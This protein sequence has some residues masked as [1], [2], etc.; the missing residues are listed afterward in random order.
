MK[1]HL[2]HENN[3]LNCGTIVQERYCSH[4]GQEN[5]EVKESFNHLVRHF[6]EDVTHYDSKFFT[7]IK[8]LIFKP[9]FLTKEYL[10]GRRASYLHP[11]RL[12]VFTS[13]LYFLAAFA[14]SHNSEKG[15][16]AIRERIVYVAKKEVADSL[17]QMLAQTTS[18]NK[19]DSIRRDVLGNAMSRLKLDS[20]RAA[21]I[22]V[23]LIGNI[24]YKMLKAYD[25]TQHA[26]PESQRDKGLKPWLYSRWLATIEHH[27]EAVINLLVE[28]TQ[29]AVPKLMFLL[30]PLFALFLK[31]FYDRKKYYYADHA[32]FSLHFH[33]AVFLLFLVFNLINKVLPSLEVFNT[34]LELVLVIIFLVVALKNTYQQKTAVSVGKAL[35]LSLLYGTFIVAGFIII[36]LSALL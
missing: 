21:E 30:L 18:G 7:T 14:F 23:Q 29:H 35:G 20:L 11:I 2:R 16:E 5:T 26:L 28:K 33:S 31:L 22:D 3:C 19:A 27:G 24:D 1:Q 13:F 8:D 32:I 36:S 12:Y 10:S 34:I 4:C 9:G 15:E 25:S 6:F 17:N